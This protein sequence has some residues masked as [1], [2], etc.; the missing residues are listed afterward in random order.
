MDNKV[1]FQK[2]LAGLLA[3]CAEN[4]N[5]IEKQEV[6]AYFDGMDLNEEQMIL[7]FDY[8][9]AQKVL[10][11][12]YMKSEELKVKE[13][14]SVHPLTEEEKEYLDNYEKELQLMNGSDLFAEM[15]PQIVELAKQMN[16]P[17]VFIGD[18]IQ[19]GNMGLMTAHAEGKE[20][21]AELL[22]A[23]RGEM[24]MYLES[25]TEIKLQDKK[26]ADKVNRLDEE[27]KKLTE[28]MGRK[29]TIDELSQFT[30]TSEEEIEDILR[31]A[32]E[33]VGDMDEE[34]LMED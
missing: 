23:I 6:E 4:G 20:E 22:E 5:V 12:R 16:H 28:E 33:E 18:L 19:E 10:V 24:Q 13:E 25:Q 7:V 34:E 1:L 32:G 8:L 30:A 3:L 2:K 27:I 21:K 17:D 26:M 31:L 29:I 9:L 14:E 11:K 15:L